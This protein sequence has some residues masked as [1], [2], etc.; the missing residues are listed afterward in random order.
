MTCDV[1]ITYSWNRVGYCILRNLTD[2]GLTVITADASKYNTCS[3]SNRVKESF[4]YADPFTRPQQFIRDLNLIIAENQPKVLIPTH[5]ETFIIAKYRECLPA[6]IIIPIMDFASL[7][8]ANHKISAAE[9]AVQVAVPVP[10]IYQPRSR[11]E[12]KSLES[13][14]H[15][16]VVLKMPKSN[17]A[18]NVYYAGNFAE[19]IKLFSQFHQSQQKT[20]NRIYLQDY[21]HGTGYGASFLYNR[22]Q[23]VTGFVHKRLTEKTHTGGVS[24]KRASV[25]NDS[26]LDYGRRI[27]DS[28]KWHGPAMVEFKYDEQTD[29]AW[30]IEIN[31]RYWGSL[32]LPVAAGLPIPYWHYCIAVN[33]PFEVN[34]YR[35][36]IISKWILGEMIALVERIMSRKL[37]WRELCRFFNF[38][39]DNYDDFKKDDPK[40]FI[41]E[42]LYYFQKLIKSGKLNPESNQTAEY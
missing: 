41:G 31:P 6:D 33:Q 28:L 24:T 15:Y 38:A 11:A 26:L 36:G 5:E 10:R 7:I 13:S 25:K 30:F 14:F 3:L 20:D 40:A 16:P 37:S 2:N 27:L 35:S 32:S 22:G 4:V 23:M 8:K 39:A 9:I 12:L 29:K 1:L 17:A 18:K 21:V 19:L 34:D 42:I